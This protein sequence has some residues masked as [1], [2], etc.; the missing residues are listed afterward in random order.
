MVEKQENNS[1]KKIFSRTA[2]ASWIAGIGA[3]GGTLVNQHPIEAVDAKNMNVSSLMVPEAAEAIESAGLVQMKTEYP[4]AMPIYTTKERK[5]NFKDLEAVNSEEGKKTVIT[6]LTGIDRMINEDNPKFRIQEIAGIRLYFSDDTNKDKIVGF[7]ASFLVRDQQTGEMKPYALSQD[8]LENETKSPNIIDLSDDGNGFELGCME[9]DGQATYTRKFEGVTEQYLDNAGE[10]QY[11]IDELTAERFKKL[12]SL[13]DYC[14]NW[15]TPCT[16]PIEYFKEGTLLKWLKINGPKFSDE[17]YSNGSVAVY[18]NS[19]VFIGGSDLE[20]KDEWYKMWSDPNRKP[21][22]LV[23]SYEFIADPDYGLWQKLIVDVF[24][25]YNS[26][27]KTTNFLFYYLSPDFHHHVYE[28]RAMYC[29]DM[30]YTM[31]VMVETASASGYIPK[32]GE[33]M[34]MD[35]MYYEPK[36]N[37]ELLKK[38]AK[39]KKFPKELEGRLLIALTSKGD[40][41]YSNREWSPQELLIKPW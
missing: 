33:N 24:A 40:P 32:R 26:L 34:I 1:F 15:K 16:I 36:E 14:A 23:G 17:V 9:I 29:R 3:L 10:W 31:P 39:T 8:S 13:K 4:T 25:V 2:A 12:D 35:T 21:I 30:A 6:F 38:W 41:D 7:S 28:K 5:S 27:D 11:Y 19:L 18:K 22:K 20:T 37:I